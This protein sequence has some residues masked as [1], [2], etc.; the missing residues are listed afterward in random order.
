MYKREE[1][2]GIIQNQQNFHQK[3]IFNGMQ[4]GKRMPTDIDAVMEF[5]NKV[6]VFWELKYGDAEIPEGQRLLYERIADAWAKDGKEAVLFL[7]SHMTPS[8]EDIQLQNAMV[9]KFYYKGDWREVKEVKTA[10]ER[11]DDF[12]CY[13]EK[14]HPHWNLNIHETVC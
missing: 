6:L 14:K 4:W 13:C 10:K 1:D 5:K 3:V 11:T 8:C 12:L 9:T 2:R 7:C